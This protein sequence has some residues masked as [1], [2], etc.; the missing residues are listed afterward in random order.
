MW[1]KKGGIVDNE[2]IIVKQLCPEKFQLKISIFGGG[3]GILHR[4]RLC[5]QVSQVF[6]SE[7]VENG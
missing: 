4:L 2:K 6:F 3:Y 7:E 5:L 1:G